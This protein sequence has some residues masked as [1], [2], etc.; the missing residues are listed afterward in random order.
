MSNIKKVLSSLEAGI[1]NH[2]DAEII[3]EALKE[4]EN[5]G[6]WKRT[7]DHW[8]DSYNS[9]RTDLEMQQ[10]ANVRLAVENKKLKN[11]LR[12]AMQYI[13]PFQLPDDDYDVLNIVSCTED[14]K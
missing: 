13:D 14:K 7:A 3:I 8:L 9:I 2:N 11:A 4:L 10:N 12:L 5:Q 1:F 6:S